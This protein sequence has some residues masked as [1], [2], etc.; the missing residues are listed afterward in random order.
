LNPRDYKRPVSVLVVIY[1]AVGEVL[2]LERLQPAGYWQS[3]TG[4]LHWNEA[5]AEAARR[6]LSEETGLEIDGQPI[7][8]GYCNRFE[9]LPAWRARYAPQSRENVEHVFRLEL[10]SRV[11]VRLNPGEHRDFCW[12]PAGVAAQRASSYTNQ[13]AIERLVVDRQ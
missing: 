8:C 7:D 2:L 3:V 9:I 12:L 5:P 4:S 11:P 6:E 1:T 10:P 13:M